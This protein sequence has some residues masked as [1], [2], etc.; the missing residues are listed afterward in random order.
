MILGIGIDTV[1]IDRFA[2]WHTLPRIQLLRIF[3]DQEID[4]C[5]TVQKK[6]AE[7]FA[8]RFAAREAFFKAF[9]SA[10][11]E[12][13][14][15]LLTV[16]R[17]VEII[18]DSRGIASLAIDWSKLQPRQNEHPHVHLSL[19]HSENTATAYVIIEKNG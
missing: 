11:P 18:R 7:R 17:Y 6:T 1:E 8:V 5:L 3:R 14:I 9:C 16:C 13:I 12:A 4:Y 19:A 2:H 10:Y 15:P